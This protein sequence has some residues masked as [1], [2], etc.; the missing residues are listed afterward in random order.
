MTSRTDGPGSVPRAEAPAGLGLPA[1]AWLAPLLATLLVRLPFL[2]AAWDA[3]FIGDE[4]Q[5]LRLGREWADFG[6]YSGQWPPVVPGLVAACFTA[7][8][9]GGVHAARVVMTALA[10]VACAL[11]MRLARDVS[12]RRAA[13][14]AGWLYA[15]YLPLVPY[16]HLVKSEGPYLVAFL[17]ALVLLARAAREREAAPAWV[18]PAAGATLGLS[19][20]TRE[21]G[22][23][24]LALALPWAAC[25][26]RATRRAGARAALTLGAS[27]A[28]VI[29]P[30]TARNLFAYGKVVP[31]AVTTGTN[32]YLGFNDVYTN[33]DLPRLADPNPEGVP[34]SGLRRALL[35]DPPEG[36]RR[37]TEGNVAARDA[38]HARM[39][40]AFVLEH[41]G[42]V[43]RT[44]VVRFADFFTP[45]SYTVKHLRL[46]SYGAPLD[47]LAARRGV[48]WLAVCEVLALLV[49]GVIGYAAVRFTPGA[50]ALLSV[51]AVA[52]TAPLLVVSMSRFRVPLEALLVVVAAALVAGPREAVP[53]RRLLVAAGMLAALGLAWLL[54][55]PPTV[56]SLEAIQ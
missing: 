25:A 46:G 13:T 48:A 18:L 52:V 51:A 39:G 19:A 55:L 38:I 44:R 49:L 12:G 42:Y 37:N 28:L 6:A 15:L 32:L 54:S 30:W 10:V 35:A 45:L 24:V 1:R 3:S 27:A 5:Y 34:G 31:L 47:G 17:G 4:P 20:L 53:G 43:L 22:A 36:W 33:F 50:R 16:A 9:D 23:L 40:L 56:A 8:G 26:T 14:W 11:V 7:F 41:P 29:A 2:G 21:S